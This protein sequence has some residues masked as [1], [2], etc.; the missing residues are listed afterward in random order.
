[1]TWRIEIEF[2]RATYDASSVLDNGIPEWPPH[3]ARLFNAL[4]DAAA[5]DEVPEAD[6][7]LLALEAMSPPVLVVRSL[8][9]NESE[10]SSERVGFVPTNQHT[11]KADEVW[12]T[13]YPARIAKGP[14]T[15]PRTTGGE[16]VTMVWED[17]ISPDH[18]HALEL[19][20]KLVG[21]LGRATTPV[22]VRCADGDRETSPEEIELRST[23]GFEG[24]EMSLPRPGYLAALRSAYEGQR[25][26]HQVPRRWMAYSERHT[27]DIVRS[28]FG[29]PH[30]LPI[31]RP[32]D[33]RHLLA[34]TSRLRSAIESVL[35]PAPAVLN[36][37]P[38][39]GEPTPR[40]QVVIAG[41]SSNMGEHADGLIRGLALIC[42]ASI[43]PTDRKRILDSLG[44]VPELAL[45]QLGVVRFG[46]M[47][48]TA[49]KTLLP[50]TWTRPATTWTTVAPMV[51]D[52]YLTATDEDGWFEQVRRSCRHVDLP[53]P[54]DID[55]SPVPWANGAL[56]ATSY[57]TRRPLPKD[58][59]R[60]AARRA[61]RA[62]PAMHVRIRFASPIRG[63]VLLGNLRY[64]GFGLCQ[65]VGPIDQ[66]GVGDDA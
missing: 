16:R 24:V 48:R 4:V 52:R 44:R 15:W 58:P 45:G 36:G 41:L 60:A 46:E 22:V 18:F 40:H 5:L 42:P 51:S 29:T 25:P 50:R 3:P 12:K 31:D 7:A 59:K 33:P 61:E 49:L 2:L 30:V 56:R 32:R 39:D 65:P 35:D 21:Y 54:I 57:D 19:L 27:T 62:K 8:T 11:I 43:D 20:C 63:P 38:I 1:M 9:M 14:R 47:P 10:V 17:P 6:P 26:A 13:A 53:E 64:Y 55:Y 28:A 23:D 34:I 66:T 37:H